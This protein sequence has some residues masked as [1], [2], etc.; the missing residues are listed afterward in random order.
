[1]LVTSGVVIN[2][3]SDNSDRL[4]AHGVHEAG[5]I[6]RLSSDSMFG[7]GRGWASYPVGSRTLV[8]SVDLGA[9]VANYHLGQIVTVY[10][11][12][13]HPSTMT[14]DDEDNEAALSVLLTAVVLVLGVGCTFGAVVTGGL[15]LVRWWRPVAWV[16]G[17][18]TRLRRGEPLFPDSNTGAIDPRLWRTLVRAAVAVEKGD[19]HGYLNALRVLGERYSLAGQ[20]LFGY[21]VIFLLRNRLTAL[22]GPTPQPADLEEVADRIRPRLARLLPGQADALSNLLLTAFKLASDADAIKGAQ[23]TFAA[24]AAI[25]LLLEDG[26]RELDGVKPLLAAWLARG[27]SS[28]RRVCEA[29]PPP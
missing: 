28:I 1:M 3:T 2:V 13:R 21:Y 12:P 26:E 29:P 11:D 25:G 8:G 7:S 23:Y 27:A 18:R 9:D 19:G 17:R 20:R 6:T 16:G 15:R 4:R 14:I 24:T 5:T 10:Y 22:V